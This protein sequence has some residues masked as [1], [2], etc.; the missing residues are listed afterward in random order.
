MAGTINSLGIGSGV[1]TSDIIDKLK[2]NDQKLIVTPIETKIGLEEQ[3]SQALD[4]LDSLLSTYR[5]SVKALDNDALYQ[6]RDVSGNNDG[7]SVEADPGVDVQSFSISD[8]QLALKN[9]IES[10]QFS[11]ITDTIATADGTMNISLDGES[12]DIDYTATTTLTELKNSINDT[13]GDKVKASILQIGE[14]DYRLVLTSAET[15]SNQNIT[16]SDSAIGSLSANLYKQNDSLQS[17]AFSATTDLIASGGPGNMTV[18]VE[19]TDYL[20]NYDATTT[21]SDLASLINTAA[22]SNVASVKQTDTSAFELVIDSTATGA[23]ATLAITD[24]SG[25]LDS[26]ITNY[27]DNDLS[28]NIQEAR[29]AS[30]KYNGISIT[31]SSNNIDDL[32][33]GVNINLLQD[34]AS[35]NISIKQDS[36]K[37][38][39]EMTAMM[40]SYNELVTQ[41]DK[42]TLADLDAEKVG[43]FNGDNTINAISR[44]I[45]RALT[46]TL[47]GYSLPQFGIDITQDGQMTFNSATFASKFN[48]DTT[49]S[50]RFFSGASDV[51]DNGNITEVKGIFSNLTT[52]MDRY[53]GFNGLMNTLSTASENTTKS[54][55]E[56]RTRAQELLD[57]RYEAMT[58]RFIQYDSIISRLNNQFSTLQQ[59]I[60]MTVNGNN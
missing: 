44:E 42:L 39:D 5:T 31:R 21:L 17:E 32:I 54:L 43:I 6:Q 38:S 22:G 40:E 19:G 30:F 11:T 35:S 14:D 47:D 48:E 52:I 23:D 51:D 41:L 20:V 2:A 4:L 33:V 3:K 60:E 58:A 25:L 12:F 45:R 9:V 36:T 57:S 24:N 13:A 46:S 37:I 53:S 29:D 18:T 50:E 59:Q 1:L 16:I 10:G 26:K 55:L 8:T 34:G 49:L 28:I 7:V 15:G 27:T 56:E